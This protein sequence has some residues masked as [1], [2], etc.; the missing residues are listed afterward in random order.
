MNKR[1]LLKKALAGSKN[2]RF[3]DMVSLVEGFGFYQSRTSGS[4]HIF[5][6][7]NIP[8]LV[9]LQEVS[10]KAKPYQVR[11]FLRLVERYNLTLGDE[12]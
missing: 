2:I 11:Q 3:T 8:E 9:N 5:T 12:E 1:K 10:G 6:H 7:P 4:H